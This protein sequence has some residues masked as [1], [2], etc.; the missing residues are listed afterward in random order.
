M[1]VIVCQDT[2]DSI[3]KVKTSLV[4]KTKLI[5][6]FHLIITIAEFNPC[7]NGGTPTLE[8]PNSPLGFT[9]KCPTEFSGPTC[10]YLNLCLNY[11]QCQNNGTCLQLGE[12]SVS[13]NCNPRFT[14]PFCEVDTCIDHDKTMCQ[15]ILPYCATGFLQRNFQVL[16]VSDFC[17]K[18]CNNII[19]A[20]G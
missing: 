19:C 7:S 1:Y 11:N 13:C 4:N 9:C 8:V 15:N 14:G 18:T 17:A 5:I 10:S 20:N 12:A 2:Q 6:C 16:K 3:V